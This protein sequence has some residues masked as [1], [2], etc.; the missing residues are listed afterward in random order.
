MHQKI[1]TMAVQ[2][3]RELESDAGAKFEKSVSLDASRVAPQISW[4]TNPAMTCNV[5]EAVP[6]PAEYA[7]GNAGLEKDAIAALKYMDLEKNTPMTDIKIDR[8]FIGSCTN[9]G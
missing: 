8:V 1:G 7:G 6:D 5:D 2:E 4:G 9:A 3:W